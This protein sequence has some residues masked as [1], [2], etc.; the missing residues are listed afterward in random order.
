MA[1]I[2]LDG[3]SAGSEAGEDIY[4]GLETGDILYFPTTPFVLTAEEQSVLL[5]QKQAETSLH[6]NIS[7]RPAQDRLKG[8][9]QSD[10]AEW[11]RVHGVMRDYSQRAIAF[12]ASFLSRYARDWKVDYA[13][14]R[15]IEEQG[16]NV[17]HRSRND[18]IH[19]DSFPSRP[20]HGD[21]LLRIFTNINPE[22]PRIWVTSDSFETLA[23]QYAGKARLP[24]RPSPLRAIGSRA[25]RV[26][27]GAGLPV[28]DRPPYDQFMLRFHHYLKENEAFQR[29]CPKDRWE[30]PPGSSWI[31]FTDTTSHACLSGQYAL[32]QTF[33]VRR[34]SLAFPERS[35]IA[36]LEG[37]T[38][39]PLAASGAK[40]A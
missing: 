3:S 40:S 38:G 16:R 21:R 25:L 32:E 12:M 19:V 4:R 2:T 17:S 5:A 36:I 10:T 27:S 34:G 13:S 14:F 11:K 26:L 30:F 7:Y 31:V 23:W 35:P 8:I 1:R 18:L 20:S 37:M 9:D 33:I 6:K 39:F 22:R 28:V 24:R 15:P 29:D